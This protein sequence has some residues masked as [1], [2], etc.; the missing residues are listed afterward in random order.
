[1]PCIK[2]KLFIKVFLI[3]DDTT[4]IA[5]MCAGTAS[6]SGHLAVSNHPFIFADG[7]MGRDCSMKLLMS[8]FT[9]PTVELS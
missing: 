2:S 7:S 3:N 1:M 4:F 8:E 5:P 9:L 6:F